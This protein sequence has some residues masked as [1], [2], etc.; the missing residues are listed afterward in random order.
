MSQKIAQ[1][2]EAVIF[3]DKDRIVK[4]RIKKS[5]R[6]KVIDDNLRKA[7]TKREA[8]LL[9]KLEHLKFP[10]PKVISTDDIEKIEMELD[11]YRAFIRDEIRKI[12]GNL[13][14]DKMLYN[15]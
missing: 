7:R 6:L 2:A 5:Y 4:D 3:L 10:C 14:L 11:G 8:K 15:A 9:K 13:F 1:G 12:A